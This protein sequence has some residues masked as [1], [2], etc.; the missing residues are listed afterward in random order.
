MYRIE[1]N[2]WPALSIPTLVIFPVF[3]GLGGLSR[4]IKIT[5]EIAPSAIAIAELY[6]KKKSTQKL[7]CARGA[8]SYANTN[9]SSLCICTFICKPCKVATMNQNAFPSCVFEFYCNGKFLLNDSSSDLKHKKD[10]L[11]HPRKTASNKSKPNNMD[12]SLRCTRGYF[13]SLARSA[14]LRA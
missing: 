5:L 14:L 3:L 11:D 12:H 4:H 1:Q 13:L 8:R 7:D 6:K 2:Y 10:C 9:T